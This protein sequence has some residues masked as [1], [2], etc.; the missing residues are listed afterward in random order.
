MSDVRYPH[1]TVPLTGVEGNTLMVVGL[2]QRELRR[3]GL[4]DEAREF[5]TTAL[6]G[7]WGHLV[8]TVA[9]WVSVA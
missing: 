1:I 2:V 9:A 7:D 6:A 4:V 3:N 5:T 8:S